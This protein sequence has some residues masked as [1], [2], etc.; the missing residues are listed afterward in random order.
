MVALYLVAHSGSAV[1]D[2]IEYEFSSTQ[3]SLRWETMS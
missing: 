2:S 3:L 1:W